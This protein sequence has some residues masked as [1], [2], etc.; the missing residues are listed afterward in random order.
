MIDY[1]GSQWRV[2]SDW[3]I[4]IAVLSCIA[5]FAIAVGLFM[6]TGYDG[7]YHSCRSR[8][9]ALAVLVALVSTLLFAPGGIAW[10]VLASLAVA[11]GIGIA[12]VCYGAIRGMEEVPDAEDVVV[13][14]RELVRERR[15]RGQ[16]ES[17][18]RALSQA[19]A[20]ADAERGLSK[21]AR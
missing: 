1:I 9:A 6:P 11:I 10:L 7:I 5:A 12:L 15:E 17:S 18:N 20:P 4:A 16:Q 19:P 3:Q 8:V 2:L 21:A 13:D 14:L